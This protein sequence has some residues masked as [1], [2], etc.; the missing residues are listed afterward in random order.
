MSNKNI[1]NQVSI[2]SDNTLSFS[3]EYIKP[4]NPDYIPYS[5]PNTTIFIIIL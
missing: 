4:E 5:F 3:Q 1:V 2:N